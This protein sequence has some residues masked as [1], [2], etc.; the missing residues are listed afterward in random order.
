LRR[1]NFR[2]AP[3]AKNCGQLLAAP[4]ALGEML[5]LERDLIR[6]ERPLAVRRQNVRVGT[7][8][9]RRPVARK[10]PPE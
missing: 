2:Y 7:G 5:L 6:V 10:A 9:A 3:G 4:R 8:F 1:R